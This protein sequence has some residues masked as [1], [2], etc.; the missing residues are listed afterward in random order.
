MQNSSNFQG[1]TA[2]S[3]AVRF[4][5]DFADDRTRDGVPGQR[6]HNPFW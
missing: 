4:V 3:D 5:M 1:F 6:D 2:F